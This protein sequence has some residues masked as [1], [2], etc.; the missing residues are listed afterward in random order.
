LN[1]EEGV[2]L[3]LERARQLPSYYRRALDEDSQ[4]YQISEV[5]K[6]RGRGR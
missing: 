1:L 6:R 4:V 5:E 2:E 3:A